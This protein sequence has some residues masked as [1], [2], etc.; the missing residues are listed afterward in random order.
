VLA[1]Y[2]LKGKI[3]VIKEGTMDAERFVQ[4]SQIVEPL[5]CEIQTPQPAVGEDVGF[6]D[7]VSDREIYPA[8]ILN[9][10]KTALKN[11][12]LLSM[13]ELVAAQKYTLTFEDA[14]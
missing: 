6:F 10:M 12:E 5:G 7:V 8:N 1:Y 2:G 14:V 9:A 4:V 13:P 3:E 11:R